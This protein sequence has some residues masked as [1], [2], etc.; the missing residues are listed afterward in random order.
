MNPLRWV[1]RR[2]CGHGEREV[3]RMERRVQALEQRAERA[4]KIVGN[5]A[6]KADRAGLGDSVPYEPYAPRAPRPDG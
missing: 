2:Y 1:A 6:R 3:T 5:A 4:R